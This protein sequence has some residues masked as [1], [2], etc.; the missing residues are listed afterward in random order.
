MNQKLKIILIGFMFLLLASC[1]TSPPDPE[2]V[3]EAFYLAASEDRTEDVF[4]YLADDVVLDLDTCRSGDEAREMIKEWIEDPEYQMEW[5]GEDYEVEGDT[6]TVYVKIYS[7]GNLFG[8][9]TTTYGVKDGLIQWQN[10][11]KP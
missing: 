7:N 3:I 2:E 1:A 9:T 6:V 10:S 5:V 11:C 8:Q 4:S